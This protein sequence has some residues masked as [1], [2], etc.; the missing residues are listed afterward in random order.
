MAPHLRVGV[1]TVPSR[2]FFGDDAQAR[3]FQASLETL[4]GLGVKIA[5]IDFQAF[6]EVA[7]LLYEGSWVAERLLVIDDL[8][9]RDPAAIHPVTRGIIEAAHQFSATDT[10]QAMYR[11]RDLAAKTARAMASVDILCVPSIPRFLSRAEVTADP[12]GANAQLGTYTNFVN[13]LNLSAVAVPVA[14]RD[15]GRPGGITLIGRAGADGQL[16]DIAAVVQR[17]MAQNLGATSWTL[18]PQANEAAQIAADECAVVAVGA[19]M[20]GL[21]LNGELTSLGGRFVRAARTAAAYRLY[22]LAGGPPPRPG[23]V[24]DSS[25]AAIDVEVWALPSNAVGDFL[26]KIPSP[27][28]L[29]TVN[30]EDGTR[31]HGFLCESIAIEDA[32]DITHFGGWRA[33]LASLSLEHQPGKELN[34]ATA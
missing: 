3:S 28:G 8:L 18:P 25:G 16:A 9:R 20:S 15:D 22:K 23:L 31:A 4:D 24:R 5:E 30:L 19:H 11:L 13:L 33:F 32:E 1:P 12:V 27:L 2:K 7:E 6:Y 21:P 26:A 14:A 29:G 10:F 17:T 34:H